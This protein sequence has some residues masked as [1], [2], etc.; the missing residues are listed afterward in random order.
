MQGHVKFF[1]SERGFGFIEVAGERD[2][3]FHIHQVLQPKDAEEVIPCGAS[4]SFDIGHDTRSG[5]RQAVNVQIRAA[6]SN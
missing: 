4:V 2:T 5:R 6:V 3:F 1:D